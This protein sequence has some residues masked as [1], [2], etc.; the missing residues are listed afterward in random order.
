ML[1]LLIVQWSTGVKSD[2]R[3]KNFDERPHRRGIFAGE[4]M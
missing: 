3:S 1:G 4:L 2:K